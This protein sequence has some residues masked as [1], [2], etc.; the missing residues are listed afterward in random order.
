[1]SASSVRAG[2]VS[3]RRRHFPGAG[4]LFKNMIWIDFVVLAIIA[5]SALVSLWRGFMREFLSLL[6]WVAAF[7]AGVLLTQRVAPVLAGVI[8]S[9]SIRVVVAF[10]ALFIVTLLLGGMINHFVGLAVQKTGLAGTDRMLGVVFGV[11]RGVAIVALL[12]LLAG[13]TTI[14]R[15]SWWHASLLLAYF[16]RLAIWVTGFMPPDLASHFA[17]H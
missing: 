15:E 1:M 14:P 8:A 7:L 11:L 12:V 17:Y 9:Q 16:Q 13:L 4:R 2:S 10:A 3:G 5:L 6:T